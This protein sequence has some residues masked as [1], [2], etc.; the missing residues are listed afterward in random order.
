MSKGM[1]VGIGNPLGARALHLLKNTRAITFT[2]ALSRTAS[3][4]PCL[5]GCIRMKNQDVDLY[6][7]VPLGTKV[8]FF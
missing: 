3:A 6:S 5:S 4:R 1:E 8:V 2:G 7:R